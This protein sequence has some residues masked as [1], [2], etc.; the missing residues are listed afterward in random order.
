VVAKGCRLQCSPRLGCFRT[1]AMRA[2]YAPPQW[3]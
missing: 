2:A 1:Y 3:H